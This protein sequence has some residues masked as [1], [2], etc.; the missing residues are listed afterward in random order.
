M[1]RIC[2][3]LVLVFLAAIILPATGT[4]QT[5]SDS[6][7]MTNFPQPLT[8]D[9]ERKNPDTASPSKHLNTSGLQPLTDQET[10]LSAKRK[11]EAKEYALRYEI[12]WT[13][14]GFSLLILALAGLAIARFKYLSRLANWHWSQWNTDFRRW[15]FLSTF[16]VVGVGLCALF[17]IVEVKDTYGYELTHELDLVWLAVLPPVFFGL[18]WFGYRGLGSGELVSPEDHRNFFRILNFAALLAVTIVGLLVVLVSVLLVDW[19]R[20]DTITI[21]LPLLIALCLLIATWSGRRVG[22][23]LGGFLASIFVGTLIWYLPIVADAYDVL[24]R[25]GI[26][27][28]E[29]IGG[30]VA[31]IRVAAV[32]VSVLICLKWLPPIRRVTI[33]QNSEA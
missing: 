3:V 15:M 18:A 8:Q 7:W 28:P 2:R 10:T 13:R 32:A 14:Q 5:S 23:R 11:S 25:L 29:T 26:S 4:S 12:E 17:G 16:W 30:I 19:S 9:V 27:G 22:D 1:S 24:E 6:Q 33:Q 20:N 31:A 21:T